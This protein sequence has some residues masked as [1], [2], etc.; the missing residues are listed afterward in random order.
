VKFHQKSR[1]A[2]VAGGPGHYERARTMTTE[3]EQRGLSR[4]ERE[5]MDV[6]IRRS[7]A[8]AAEIWGDL[9]N[10][11]TLDAVR[12]ALR[13]LEKRGHLAHTGDG[14]RHVYH[15]AQPAERVRESALRYVISTFFNG[16]PERLVSTLFETQDVRPR[17]SELDALAD[18]VE[19]ARAEERDS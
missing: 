6:V 12:S 9:P 8:T 18:L 1:L 3:P 10:P 7:N 11:P 15:A 14:P 16:S 13:L 19:R 17:G 5:I 4:R 2:V